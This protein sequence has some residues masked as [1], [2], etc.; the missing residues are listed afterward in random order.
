M[1]DSLS[2]A[3]S[4][5][6]RALRLALDDVLDLAVAPGGPPGWGHRQRGGWMTKR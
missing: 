3:A 2:R 1:L 5:D 6:G 4:E